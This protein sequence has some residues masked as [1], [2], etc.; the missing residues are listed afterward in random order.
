VAAD[1]SVYVFR[2]G[3]LGDTLVALPAIYELAK[4]F[5]TGNFTLITNR[6]QRTSHVTAW[7]VLKHTGLFRDVLF[8]DASRPVSIAALAARI[9]ARRGDKLLCYL[10]PQRQPRQLRRDRLFY[11]WIC[12]LDRV[13]G[14]D[15]AEE[16]EWRNPDGS[17][18]R[19]PLESD[20][21]LEVVATSLHTDGRGQEPPL[22]KPPRVALD[23]AARLLEPLSGRTIIA[24]GPGSKMPSK[25]WFLERYVETARRILAFHSHAAIA[26]FGG[27][28]ERHLGDELRARL[29]DERLVVLSGTTDIIE[30][31]AAVARC[32]LY[33]GNDTGVMHLAAVMG[34]PCVAIFSS[35]VVPGAWEP[36]GAGNAV[37]RRDLPCSGC[38]LLECV[39]EKMRCLDLITVDDAWTDIE[40]RLQRA[41]DARARGDALCCD[42][43]P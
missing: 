35:R 38:L 33:V 21:L 34:V 18:R 19:F 28:D 39:E 6:P 24:L 15:L 17:L 20:R 26:V 27:S 23:T 14:M 37:L 1:P 22:L 40:P 42:D 7:E 30:S 4:K 10:S 31:A 29:G 41:L 32:A 5:P 2:I 36:M 3:Q 9:R 11:R 43:A 25:T 12:G 13:V 8:Y 16:P